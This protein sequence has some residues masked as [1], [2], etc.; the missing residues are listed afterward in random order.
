[1]T[2]ELSRVD[3]LDDDDAV[4]GE[5]VGKRHAR[6][7]VA[8]PIAHVAHD[9]AAAEDTARLGIVVVDAVIAYVGIRHRDDLPGIGGIAQNLLVAAHRGVEDDFSEGLARASA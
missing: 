8:R 5:V 7:E 9:Q 3:S 6:P 1:M 2:H 4:G